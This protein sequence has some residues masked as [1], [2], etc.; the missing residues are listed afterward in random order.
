MKHNDLENRLIKFSVGIINVAGGLS[1]NTAGKVLAS[2]IIRPGTSTALNYGEAQFAES[3]KDFLHKMKIIL[4]ELN[5]TRVNLE[6]IKYSK[7]FKTEKLVNNLINEN[8]ELISIFV[9]SV[10][11]TKRN[12]T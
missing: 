3:R 9:S 1:Q 5:E 8:R 11:T 4:K 6:L 10:K 12:V 2:Q 7:L